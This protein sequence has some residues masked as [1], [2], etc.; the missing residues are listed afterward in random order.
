MDHGLI[1]FSWR[2]LVCQTGNNFKVILFLTNPIELLSEVSVERL[3]SKT[4]FN[5]N[6]YKHIYIFFLK[7]DSKYQTI[8][9]ILNLSF[10]QKFC[11]ALE[12]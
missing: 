12:P 1:C 10:W 9:F 8:K 5:K 3:R 6:Y 7:V 4:S 2:H 11:H